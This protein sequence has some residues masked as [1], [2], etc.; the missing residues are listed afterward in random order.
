V[1]EL[2]TPEIVDLYD[3][4]ARL[5]AYVAELAA[6]RRE[7]A[8]LEA[9]RAAAD[10]F[11]A[12]AGALESDDVVGLRALADANAEFHGALLDACRHRDLRG[13]VGRTVDAPLVFRALACFDASELERSALF[14]HLI[15]D[16]VERGEPMRA[17][18]LMAEHVLQGRDALVEHLDHADLRDV[19]EAEAA[20]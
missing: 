18:R 20:R 1:R 11:R 15:L 16:A 12:V 8:D 4:R 14:H 17:S 3:A 19:L 13:L 5:E 2:T 6:Q 9:L 7:P 10:R